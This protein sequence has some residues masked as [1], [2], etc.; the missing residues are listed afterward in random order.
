[1]YDITERGERFEAIAAVTIAQAALHLLSFG[2]R[3]LPE[4]AHRVFYDVVLTA[5]YPC[6]RIVGRCYCLARDIATWFR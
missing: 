1:V 4:K 6:G 3:I 5:V 2:Y